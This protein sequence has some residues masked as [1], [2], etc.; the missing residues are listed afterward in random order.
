MLALTPGPSSSSVSYHFGGPALSP[1]HR[2]IAVEMLAIDAMRIRCGEGPAFRSWN[3][4]RLGGSPHN[5][6]REGAIRAYAGIGFGLPESPSNEDHLQG[7]VAE[8]FWSRL[9]LELPQTADGRQLVKL[10]A[11]KPDPLEPGGD[12]LAIY[13]T[14]DGQLIFRLWEIKK[15]DTQKGVSATINRAG[16]QLSTRG[17]EYLAKLAGPETMETPDA[18]GDLYREIIELWLDKSARAGVGVSVGT[19]DKYQ[20]KGSRSFKSLAKTFPTFVNAGQ[21]ESIVVAIPA[22]PDFALAVREEIWK[23]L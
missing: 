15:H 2:Q 4:R 17:H 14:N 22:F 3:E 18:L 20:P 9:I 23:G 21:L 6:L 11:A 12:G 10:H 8:L 7:L 5:P 1:A 13:A 19:S 16:K